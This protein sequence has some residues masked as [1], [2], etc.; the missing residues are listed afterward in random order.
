MNVL[1]VASLSLLSC[2]PLFAEEL[3][4]VPTDLSWSTWD[5]PRGL[6]SI[7][8]DG[9]HVRRFAKRINAVADAS[10]FS[11][12]VIGPHGTCVVRTPSNQRDADRIRDQRQDTW[13]APD[14]R[15]PLDDWMDKK[16]RVTG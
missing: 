6:L 10:D 1:L 2:W 8:N 12:K 14:A 9:V 16:R 13:W 7:Q 3:F 15:S 4:T 5:Y 11:A